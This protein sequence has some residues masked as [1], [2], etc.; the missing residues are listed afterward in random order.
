MR[1]LHRPPPGLTLVAYPPCPPGHR[2]Y[3]PVVILFAVYAMGV[4]TLAWRYR[5]RWQG[6]AAIVAGI[7]PV[8]LSVRLDVWLVR[9]LFDEDAAFLYILGGAYAGL[10]VVIGLALFMQ[11]RP[12]PGHACDG[13]GYDLRGLDHGV[14]PECGRGD[15]RGASSPPAPHPAGSLPAALADARRARASNRFSAVTTAAPASA[16]RPTPHH[17]GPPPA[18]AP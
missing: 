6:F 9:V 14:C 2:P 4:W 18:S 5:R 12:T 16:A 10:L 15:E 13:C 17:E 7:P 1:S 11:P 8:L 3:T